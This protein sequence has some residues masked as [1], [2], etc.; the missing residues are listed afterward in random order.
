MKITQQKFYR[1]NGGT[2]QLKGVIPDVQL[3]D[4]YQ[5]HLGNDFLDDNMLALVRDRW[6]QE[7]DVT[8]VPRATVDDLN[9]NN[10]SNSSR[11]IYDGSYLRFKNVIL[12]YT[13]PT[14]LTERLK[15]RSLR[16]YA[17]AQNLF[18]FTDYPGF[19]PEVNFAGTSNTTLGV[20]FYTFPQTRTITFGVNVGF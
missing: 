6:Q 13:L 12:G 2:T 15:M 7:G 10:R 4:Q 14:S 17:Q 5:Q 9:N 1:I 18:T 11:F 8:D 20:D 19:D 3:P 16:V